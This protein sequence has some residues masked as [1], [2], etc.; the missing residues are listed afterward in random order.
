M[1]AL[2]DLVQIVFDK[3]FTGVTGSVPSLWSSA[4]WWSSSLE[5]ESFSDC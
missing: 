4:S 2:P 3:K 1:T 5:E